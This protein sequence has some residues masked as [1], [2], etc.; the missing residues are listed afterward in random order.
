MAQFS[1]FSL[2][3][4]FPPPLCYAGSA[5]ELKREH[6]RFVQEGKTLSLFPSPPHTA[7]AIVVG[8]TRFVRRSNGGTRQ[9]GR[10]DF[11]GL[12][13]YREG[14]GFG[15]REM[16]EVRRDGKFFSSRCLFLHVLHYYSRYWKG[17]LQ[18][19]NFPRIFFAHT[20]GRREKKKFLGPFS[21][22]PIAAV[23][24]SKPRLTFG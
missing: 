12:A 20:L 6:K 10:V 18:R 14:P 16:R 15:D 22:P 9:R 5:R 7:A 23:A 8:R 19:T 21:P 11:F 13:M 1:F 17:A 3:A 4:L 2:S 24:R